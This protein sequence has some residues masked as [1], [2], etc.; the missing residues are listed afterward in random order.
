[1]ATTS[2]PTFGLDSLSANTPSPSFPA[3]RP[4]TAYD[5]LQGALETGSDQFVKGLEEKANA[6]ATA[7][8]D[9]FEALLKSITQTPGTSALTDAAYRDAGVDSAESELKDINNQILQEQVSLRRSI[10]AAEKNSTG[11]FGGALDQTI[12]DLKDKSL[13]RQADL[14]VIQMAKQGKFDSAKAIA[15]RAVAATAEAGKQRIDALELLYQ[16]NKDLFSEADQRAFSA[17]QDDRKRVLDEKVYEQRARFDASIAAAKAGPAAAVA[18]GSPDLSLARAQ[19]N[20]QNVDSILADSYLNTAVGPNALARASFTNL[21]TGG[22]TN[23]IA[24]IEQLRSQLSLDSLIQAKAQGATFGALSDS[25]LKILSQS[26][27]KLGNW[28]IKDK[29]GNVVGYR[30]NEADFKKELDTINNF[31]KLDYILKGGDPA[32]VNVQLMPDGTY[33]TKNS[34][35]TLTKLG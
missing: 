17:A 28:A 27:T 19:Q 32:D 16:E 5:G 25:E 18:G 14:S 6:A 26:G 24:G 1:M 3:I 9:T 2:A 34:D 13:A 22:K 29:D 8:D 15:D 7:K 23:V 11:Q 21:F 35:D 30:A 12:Q 33:W 10:E 20:V 4:S 31:Q